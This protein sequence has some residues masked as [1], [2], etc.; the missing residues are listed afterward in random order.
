MKVFSSYQGATS[1]S[2]SYLVSG[3]IFAVT[4]ASTRS[5]KGM[6]MEERSSFLSL[7]RLSSLFQSRAT[8]WAGE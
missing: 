8:I 6:T 7:F 2:R 4:M 3:L 1:L 5:T